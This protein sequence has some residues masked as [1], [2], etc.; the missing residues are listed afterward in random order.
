[1]FAQVG[2]AFTGTS[3]QNRADCAI[4]LERDIDPPGFQPRD[5]RAVLGAKP[6]HLFVFGVA[7]GHLRL[8]ALVGGL[9]YALAQ[10]GLGLR[11]TALTYPGAGR[12]AYATSDVAVG[13]SG[14]GGLGIHAEKPSSTSANVGG[15]SMTPTMLPDCVFTRFTG[16]P[17]H[18][19]GHG[20]G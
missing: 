2:L 9:A 13:V 6:A 4:A 8:V 11:L 17:L 15:R 16:E 19:C 12:D 20:D 14:F 7:D 5:T 10:L 3:A 1:M 18:G